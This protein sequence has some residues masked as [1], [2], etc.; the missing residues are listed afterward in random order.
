M[1]LP[2]GFWIIPLSCSRFWADQSNPF[3]ARPLR[4]SVKQSSPNG[5]I[6]LV[7]IWLHGLNSFSAA[8]PFLHYRH[9]MTACVLHNSFLRL[10]ASGFIPID[11]GME[12][13]MT[14]VDA[15]IQDRIISA[16][17]GQTASGR[18]GGL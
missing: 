14:V 5:V 11:S 8:I 6:Y 7:F 16:D 18:G 15:E 9:P 4:S 17:V 12:R 2:A 1:A 10:I 13:S 3:H